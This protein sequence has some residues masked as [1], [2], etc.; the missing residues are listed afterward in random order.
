MANTFRW[1]DINYR[2]NLPANPSSLYQHPNGS[3]RSPWDQPNNAKIDRF[4]NNA[5]YK[6]SDGWEII[7]KY[8]G[9]DNQII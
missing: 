1:Q 9:Y 6:W 3:I 2:S 8:N 4:R 5:D 7:T